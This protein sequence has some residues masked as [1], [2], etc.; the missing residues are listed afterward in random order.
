MVSESR[1][2]T[3]RILGH[4]YRIRSSESEE[5][6][7]EVAE[8]V[9]GVMKSISSH[10]SS[11]TPATVAVLAAL[12]IAEELFRERRDGH[13]GRDASE[14]DERMRAI[15]SRLDEVTGDGPKRGGR[16]A[17]RVGSRG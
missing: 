13:N 9:D 7:Q 17:A 12:N 10:M 16:V 14:V 6:V 15:M 4:E 3:V 5:F 1:A 11:G 2:T 8:Y